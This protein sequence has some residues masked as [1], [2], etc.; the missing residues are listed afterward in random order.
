MQNSDLLS[1]NQQATT[2]IL[3][4][5]SV[6]SPV[7]RFSTVYTT[8]QQNIP[9][10][11]DYLGRSVEKRA[12]ASIWFAEVPYFILEDFKRVLLRIYYY[13]YVLLILY[14]YYM[15]TI[16]HEQDV[17]T[18]NSSEM[19][20]GG[21][22]EIN[23]KQYIFIFVSKNPLWNELI[24]KL[25]KLLQEFRPEE[26]SFNLLQE[27]EKFSLGR[28][29]PLNPFTCQGI[30]TAGSSCSQEWSEV[31]NRCKTI[32]SHRDTTHKIL[33]L[34]HVVMR[35]HLKQVV[36]RPHL[37]KLS[38]NNKIYIYKSLNPVRRNY[39]KRIHA[40]SGPHTRSCGRA[41]ARTH[42]HTHARARAHTHTRTHTHTRARARRHA[43][44]HART[45]AQERAEREK[46]RERGT[47]THEY[48][49]YTKHNVRPPLPP[50]HPQIWSTDDC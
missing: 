29:A 24:C 15:I 27:H 31:K 6:Q 14:Y 1:E 48:S 41:S 25:C 11:K 12:Q 10:F 4:T 5:S 42:T 9:Y 21:E 35:P 34:R 32:I 49:D 20:F 16:F 22:F 44:T 2:S 50:S 23:V 28:R 7:N 18:K 3:A 39:S 46:E 47:S 13:Y 30:C 37:G 8:T 17:D 33:E 38:I 36:M 19:I 45:H 43:C 40:S 26:S